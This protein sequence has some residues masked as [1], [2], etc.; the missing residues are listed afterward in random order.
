[1]TKTS[2][3]PILEVKSV[4]IKNGDSTVTGSIDSTHFMSELGDKMFFSHHYSDNPSGKKYKGLTY[5]ALSNITDVVETW[6]QEEVG[7]VQM[8]ANSRVY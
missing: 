6:P 2:S 3:T 5:T 8:L 1:V 4:Y 7:S